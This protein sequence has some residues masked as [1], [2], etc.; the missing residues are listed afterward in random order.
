VT[1]AEPYSRS[2]RNA[3]ARGWDVISANFLL[4][5]WVRSHW[6]AFAETCEETG[7]EA[8]PGDWRVAKCVL[9]ADDPAV[10]RE[11]AFGASS[12]Y[13]FYF[14]QLGF[15]LIRAGRINLFKHADDQPDE[16][17]TTDYLLEELVIAGTPASVADQLAAFREQVG[18]FGTLLYCGMDWAD[19]DL[20]RR[21]MRLMAD[22]VVP[23]LGGAYR[24][25]SVAAPASS[26]PKP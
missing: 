6:E 13:R 16:E 21:S 7:R 24:A 12:P 3:A 10:A 20:A 18:P 14:D 25:G 11:Y 15:K 1:A 23:R 17:I 9:V 19:A 2:V 22:E 4:P 26:S 5:E 8:D